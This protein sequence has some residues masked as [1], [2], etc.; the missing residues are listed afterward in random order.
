MA[1]SFQR[2]DIDSANSTKLV[3]QTKSKSNA[4]SFPSR[5]R[6]IRTSSILQETTSQGACAVWQCFKLC[7]LRPLQRLKLQYLLSTQAKRRHFSENLSNS[8]NGDAFE[9]RPLTVVYYLVLQNPYSE[10]IAFTHVTF[11]LRIAHTPFVFTTIAQAFRRPL[12]FDSCG[13][14]TS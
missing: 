3:L 8:C 13:R 1:N 11:C 10:F 9:R 7:R 5:K 12:T 2:S 14:Q 4:G 6:W